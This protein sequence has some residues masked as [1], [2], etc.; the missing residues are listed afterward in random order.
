MSKMNIGIFKTYQRHI[1]VLKS[2]IR[3]EIKC[4]ISQRLLALFFTVLSSLAAA[5]HLPT[6][7]LTWAL[8]LE[9]GLERNEL[10]ETP[11]AGQQTPL[12]LLEGQLREVFKPES[13]IC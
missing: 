10:N 13:V 1:A 6:I 9:L 3:V 2:E 7:S 11:Q 5:Q 12:L 8:M 4:F